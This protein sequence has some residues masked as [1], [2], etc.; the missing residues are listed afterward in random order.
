MNILGTVYCMFAKDGLNLQGN[1]LEISKKIAPGIE[2]SRADVL[3][4]VTLG[5]H[6][7]QVRIE[8][9]TITLRT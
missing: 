1:Q 8:T 7:K 6:T 9:I 4:A 2:N 5:G 3:L